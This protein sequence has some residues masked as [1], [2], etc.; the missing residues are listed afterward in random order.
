MHKQLRALNSEDSFYDWPE[1]EKRLERNISAV[2]LT[3][4]QS[5]VV[6]GP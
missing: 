5:V 6:I 1:Y 3:V 2:V 4:L